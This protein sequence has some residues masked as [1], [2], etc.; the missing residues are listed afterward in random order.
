[1]LDTLFAKLQSATDPMA[2]Q[3]LEAAI[4]EQWTMAPDP[5]QRALMLRGIAE[6]QQQEPRLIELNQDVF[7][8]S[9]EAADARTIEPLG[10]HRREWAAQIRP[11]QFGPD[12]AAAAHPERQAAPDRLDFRQFR[13]RV[14]ARVGFATDAAPSWRANTAAAILPAR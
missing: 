6:M 9:G 10:Q 2:I 14:V 11:A 5:Q 13:H 12:D 1:M 4:W 8:A 3:S 7:A